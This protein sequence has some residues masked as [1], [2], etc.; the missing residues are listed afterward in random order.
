MDGYITIGTELDT[1][2]F[3]KQIIDLENKLD[4]LEQERKVIAS[5]KTIS[6]S[7][8]E[9]LKEYDAQIEK[10]SNQIIGLRQKQQALAKQ[11]TFSGI[12]FQ[13]DGILKKVAKWGLALFGIRSAY[14]L[15]RQSMSTLSQQDENLASQVEY[16]RW[17]IA[18]AIAPVV[19]F[20]INAIYL[21][22]QYVNQITRALFGWDLFKGP[23]E[24]S[25]SMKSASGSAKEIKKSL[26]GFDEMN[27]LGN[28]TTA[29]GGGGVSTPEFDTKSVIDNINKVKNKFKELSKSW[30]EETEAMGKALENPKAFKEAYGNW[31]WLMMG[32]TRMGYSINNIIFGFADSFGGA[33]KIIKGIFTNDSKLIDDGF[34]QLI[35]GFKELLL[36]YVNFVY[37]RF[38]IITGTIKGGLNGLLNWLQTSFLNKM[39]E[40]FG[41]IGSII[42]YP[43]ISAVALIKGYFESGVNGIKKLFDGLVKFFK[44]DFKGGVKSIF[45]GLKDILLAPFRGMRDGINKI[46]KGLNKIKL[47]GVLGGGKI[48]IPEIPKFAQGTIINNPGR[49]VPIGIGGEA[50]REAILPLS[51]SRLLEELGSTIGKYIT[52]NLTNETKLDGRTI[53][54]KISQLNTSDNFLRNR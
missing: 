24:F 46:I 48:S 5:Q 38:E 47:P 10:T 30:R 18:N 7:D 52:I 51:D 25:K 53:A 20:I 45:G 50:G 16:I 17:T 39:R 33:F 28:N 49:G 14:S 26:A 2:S 54:R 1:K 36:G 31:D 15:I 21:I 6:E 41:P 11:E 22:L 43:I 44:G 35:Q 13:L 32:I 23:K 40:L 19:K 29:S 37:A 42:T 34:K 9:L 27:I 12:N 4:R 3:D 8:I